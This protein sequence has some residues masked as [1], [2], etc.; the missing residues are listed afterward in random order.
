MRKINRKLTDE[1]AL[2]GLPLYM[3]ILIIIAGVGTAV[4]GGWLM[5]TQS[6]ELD[7]IEVQDHNNNDIDMID[8][9]AGGVITVYVT[10]YDQ[11]GEALEDVR[12]SFQ[13]CGTGD[14]DGS[15]NYT[16][17]DGEMDFT[18]E[19]DDLRLPDHEPY[20]VIEITAEYDEGELNTPVTRE[21]TVTD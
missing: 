7:N 2:E 10:A 12:V 15:V 6:T 13:G 17:A 14:M 21:I 18:V 3:I 4:I 1:G 5:S 11:N 8:S 16:D 20:G 9:T 19:R